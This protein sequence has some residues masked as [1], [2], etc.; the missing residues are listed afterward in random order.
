MVG[1]AE[2][3][4]I[5]PG[6]PVGRSNLFKLAGGSIPPLSHRPGYLDSIFNDDERWVNSLRIKVYYY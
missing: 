4:V 1:W 3:V 6:A 5:Q 2:G